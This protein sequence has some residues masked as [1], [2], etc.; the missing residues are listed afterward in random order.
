M[1]IVESIAANFSNID[2]KN[3]EN[4]KIGWGTDTAQYTLGNNPDSTNSGNK[5]SLTSKNYIYTVR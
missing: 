5:I 4:I 3:K 1:S 2:I